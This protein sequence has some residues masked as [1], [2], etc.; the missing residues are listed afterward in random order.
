M[1]IDVTPRRMT[2]DM[3]VETGTHAPQ[4]INMIV[5]LITGPNKVE[6]RSSLL[7]GAK[8]TMTRMESGADTKL[9]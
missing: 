6:W 1:M 4:P 9:L 3:T 8:M 5:M 7:I 2:K